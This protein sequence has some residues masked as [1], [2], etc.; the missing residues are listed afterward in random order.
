MGETIHFHSFKTEVPKCL[1]MNAAQHLP[2]MNERCPVPICIRI[3]VW[4][5]A[6]ASRALRDSMACAVSF[7][8]TCASCR[9]CLQQSQD[10]DQDRECVLPMALVTPFILFNTA[11]FD[12]TPDF[13]SPV[14]EAELRREILQ[15]TKL[16]RFLSH[17]FA[18]AMH[19]I[20]IV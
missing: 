2:K 1:K 20:L 11:S 3:R 7:C 14:D 6:A 16:F 12:S 19:E 8:C 9:S 5:V 17:D 18:V 10:L 13:R 4:L 15:R